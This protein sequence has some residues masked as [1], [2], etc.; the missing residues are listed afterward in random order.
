MSSMDKLQK[1]KKNLDELIL[2]KIVNRRLNYYLIIKIIKFFYSLSFV[3]PMI[4]IQAS[5]I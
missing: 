5:G 2:K 3:E 4:N 1:E